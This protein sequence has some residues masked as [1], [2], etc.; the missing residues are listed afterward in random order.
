VTSIA[1]KTR[2]T[3]A[4]AD[5][6]F[7]QVG[8]R[9]VLERVHRKFYDKVYAH[10]WLSR[11]FDGID[12]TRIENQQTD[13]MS[14][15]MGGPAVY[16]GGMV[17]ER[18]KH[19]MVTEELFEVRSELLE[20]SLVEAGVAEDERAKWLKIDSAF[21][22]AI[23]KKSRADCTPRYTGSAILDFLKPPGV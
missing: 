8:G 20:Q 2:T 21:K 7:E 6:L 3:A 14:F 5:S 4:A 12:Q 19:M 22:H 13:F 18:H 11:Y 1:T 23:V 15:A 16:I 9:E 10:P 17:P